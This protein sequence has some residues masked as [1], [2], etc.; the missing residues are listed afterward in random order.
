[1][2]RTLLF[3][4]WLISI[5]YANAVDLTEYFNTVQDSKVLCAQALPGQDVMKDF[6]FLFGPRTFDCKSVT[7]KG[8]ENFQRMAAYLKKMLKEKNYDQNLFPILYAQ[9]ANESNFGKS[10]GAQVNNFGGKL[11]SGEG[12]PFIVYSSPEAFVD[13]HLVDLQSR[14]YSSCLTTTKNEKDNFKKYQGYIRCIL[15]GYETPE[16]CLA[17]NKL[18]SSIK[19]YCAS[20]CSDLYSLPLQT[21]LETL[22]TVSQGYGTYTNIQTAQ[23]M[24]DDPNSCGLDKLLVAAPVIQQEPIL[25]SPSEVNKTILPAESESSLEVE[26]STE[27]ENLLPISTELAPEDRPAIEQENLLPFTPQ[28]QSDCTLPAEA[29]D[30]GPCALEIYDQGKKFCDG[31]YECFCLFKQAGSRVTVVKCSKTKM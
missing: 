2:K 20:K 4:I 21:S 29:N 8:N 3:V 6:S 13:E 19:C 26:P 18:N 27:P 24:L 14:R 30:G 9:L 17:A 28:T 7:G 12:S 11:V 10:E 5:S 1:M 31:K 25:P 22:P 23:V 16:T 15:S